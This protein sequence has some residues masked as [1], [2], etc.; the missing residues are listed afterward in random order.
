MRCRIFLLP[1]SKNMKDIQKLVGITNIA[2]EIE[3]GIII[4]GEKQIKKEHVSVAIDLGETAFEDALIMW[5]NELVDSGY[6]CKASLGPE[7][8]IKLI[9]SPN[10][11]DR[12]AAG[13]LFSKFN[14]SELIIDHD[15]IDSE[16]HVFFEH[17]WY[18]Y[19]YE[20]WSKGC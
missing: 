16:W 5:M 7:T 3:T 13:A 17:N 8:K 6:R 19:I 2:E 12:K 18:P 9:I 1:E 14:I 20:V 4:K 11:C 15:L 10:H